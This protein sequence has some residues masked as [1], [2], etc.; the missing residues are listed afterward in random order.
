[1]ESY[2]QIFYIPCICFS[3][4]PEDL[5]ISIICT[6]QTLVSLEFFLG[7]FPADLKAYMGSVRLFPSAWFRLGIVILC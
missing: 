5:N 1:M 3:F 6:L 7:I 4:K 2:E